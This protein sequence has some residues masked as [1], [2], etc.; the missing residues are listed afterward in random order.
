M[1]RRRLVVLAGTIALLLLVLVLVLRSCS[2]PTHFA[3]TRLDPPTA[4]FANKA[5]LPMGVTRSRTRML[6]SVGSVS[7]R[8][9]MLGCN[10][11]RSSKTTFCGSTSGLS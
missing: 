4:V 5:R 10:G 7:R 2:S 6:I 3:I 1:S 8:S 11:V 9:R